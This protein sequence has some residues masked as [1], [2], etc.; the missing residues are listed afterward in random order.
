MKN[1]NEYNVASTVEPSA[2][3]AQWKV[4]SKHVIACDGAGSQVRMSLGI[5]SEGEDNCG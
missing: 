4:H 1:A 3:K 2:T 5:E